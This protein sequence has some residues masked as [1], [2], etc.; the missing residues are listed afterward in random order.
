[1]GGV[2]NDR[3]PLDLLPRLNQTLTSGLN[4][5]SSRVTGEQKK[6]KNWSHLRTQDN[7]EQEDALFP[8]RAVLYVGIQTV[9]LLK[10]GARQLVTHIKPLLDQM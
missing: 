8:E 3:L 6:Q 9:G 4:L 7:N 1:M 10:C 5:R 2:D